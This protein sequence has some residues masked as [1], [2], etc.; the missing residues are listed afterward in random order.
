V[1]PF[2]GAQ[3]IRFTRGLWRIFQAKACSRPPEPTTRT[4]I[5]RYPRFPSS[6]AN[7]AANAGPGR[8]E[9]NTRAASG[10]ASSGGRQ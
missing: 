1:P 8:A 2:P 5:G 6:A 3:K 10:K 4:F 9:A 7:L